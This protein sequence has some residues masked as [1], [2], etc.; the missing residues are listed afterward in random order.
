[1]GPHG[2]HA[3]QEFVV[4]AANGDCAGFFIHHFLRAF[5]MQVSQY[6]QEWALIFL[7]HSP[8][9]HLFPSNTLFTALGFLSF[10]LVT[11]ESIAPFV[12][13]STAASSA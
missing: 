8:I 13:F 4:V 3:D 6:G 7:S 2:I 11:I 10:N 9:R 5:N 1:M 12:V